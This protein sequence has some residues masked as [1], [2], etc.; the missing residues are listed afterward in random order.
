MAPKRAGGPRPSSG[1]KSSAASQQASAA[2]SSAASAKRKAEAKSLFGKL[3]ADEQTVSKPASKKTRTEQQAMNKFLADNFPGFTNEELFMRKVDGRTLT[4]RLEYDK[5]RKKNGEQVTTG[6][7]YYATLRSLYRSPKSVE[8]CL[9]VKDGDAPQDERMCY[10]LAAA[11][12][13][14]RSF[15]LLF[16]WCETVQDVN[17]TN[18]VVLFKILLTI[19]PAKSLETASATIQVMRMIRRLNLNVK[20]PEEVALMKGHFDQACV[21]SLACDKAQKRSGEAWCDENKSWA[22]LVLPED[23]TTKALGEEHDFKNV[24]DDIAAVVD[25]SEVGKR[26]LAKVSRQMRYDSVEVAITTELTKLIANDIDDAVVEAST[27][28]FLERVQACGVDPHETSVPKEAQIYYRGAKVDVPVT[29]PFDH[30]HVA[31]HALI[32]GAAVDLGLLPA[33]WCESDLLEDRP[34]LTIKIAMNTDRMKSAAKTRRVLMDHLDKEVATPETVLAVFQQ[35]KSF[36]QS[37]DRCWRVE[38]AFW[39]SMSGASAEKRVQDL[40]VSCLPSNG[41]PMTLE[42]SNEEFSRDSDSKL[43]TW[44]G[45]SYRTIF[46]TVAGYIKTMLAGRCPTVDRLCAQSF[47]TTLLARMGLFC[48]AKS[49]DGSDLTGEAAAKT[50]L[51]GLLAKHNQPEPVISYGEFTQ[52]LRFSWLLS[53]AEQKQLDKVKATA[54]KGVGAIGGAAAKTSSGSSSSTSSPGKANGDTLAMVKALFKK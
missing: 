44:A 3:E 10:A 15:D 41:K 34:G 4:E 13:A 28:A 23:S 25:S 49:E 24:R 12:D 5:A 6:K 31:M 43:L 29:S 27:K 39:V 18:I 26:L 14:K 32:R 2:A 50:M 21:K 22:C 8:S 11:A 52:V 19:S 7:F 37:T 1:P 35:K 53:P 48:C 9:Q 38:H 16:S 20:Y 40:I 47:T 33:L 54:L 36:L 51:A 17:Q 42:E 45:S 46:T 30:W